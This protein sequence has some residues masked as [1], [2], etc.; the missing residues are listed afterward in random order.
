MKP[1]NVI[2]EALSEASPL[3][4]AA[5]GVTALFG[6]PVI[7]SGLRTVGVAA[8]KAALEVS[9]QLTGTVNQARKQWEGIV[10]EAR[11]YQMPYHMEN[12]AEATVG[13]GIGGAIGAGLGSM[14]GPGV[15]TVAGG[16]I[17]GAV[18]AMVGEEVEERRNKQNKS[19]METKIQDTQEDLSDSK[20]KSRTKTSSKDKE[21]NKQR[22]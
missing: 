20:D 21:N 14:A 2:I 6:A 19:E 16:G 15:G 5:L 17:G 9:D 13:A 1:L 10:S 4:L 3:T 8:V 22:K 12:V 7:K 18:G 11:A